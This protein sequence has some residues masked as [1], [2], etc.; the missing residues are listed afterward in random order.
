MRAKHP[1]EGKA[2]D[3]LELHGTQKAIRANLPVMNRDPTAPSVLRG[4]CVQ[5]E[6]GCL[7]GWGITMA[8]GV[9]GFTL[10]CFA[11]CRSRGPSSSLCAGSEPYAGLVLL[12]GSHPSCWGTSQGSQGVSCGTLSLLMSVVERCGL[13]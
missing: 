8:L 12:L 7:Q 4:G 5:P 10:L 1:A 6:L 2:W 11:H 3:W 9:E 13:L